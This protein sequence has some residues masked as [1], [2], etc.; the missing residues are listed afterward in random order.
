MVE[1]MFFYMTE[2]LM[3]FLRDNPEIGANTLFEVIS[4]FEK[5]PSLFSD[6]LTVSLYVFPDL[7]PERQNDSFTVGS[8]SQAAKEKIVQ[9]FLPNGPGGV[10]GMQVDFWGIVP[11]AIFDIAWHWE[12]GMQD[13]FLTIDQNVRA[14]GSYIITT[15]RGRYT[16]TPGH[17]EVEWL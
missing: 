6:I 7:Y 15:D 1:A 12:G 2:A 5:N 10:A 9:R 16:F 4:F 3:G 14:F 11:G 8:Y 17:V 13:L